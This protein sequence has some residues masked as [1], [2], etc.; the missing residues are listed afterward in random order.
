[1]GK[2]TI[3]FNGVAFSRN[4]DASRRSSRVY[5]TPEWAARV[6]GVEMLH[7]EVWKAAHGPIPD[8]H[9]IHH[10]DG[11]PL[12]NTLENLECIPA[13]SHA[14]RH[15]ATLYRRVFTEDDRE[16]AAEWKRSA[17]GRAVMSGAAKD[18]WRCR[19]AKGGSREL[20]CAYCGTTFHSYGATP[21]FCSPKCRSADR[22]DRGVDNEERVCVN[23]GST[24]VVNRY[25]KTKCCSN[26]CARRRRMKP[27]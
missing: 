16:K 4:P 15:G 20:S 5:Y 24:F 10:I 3:I 12:N 11:N 19:K 7:R 17:A 1:M 23:C 6:S 21:M 22:R 8:G 9:L 18:G 2:E 13:R 26:T 27:S 14:S 25:L